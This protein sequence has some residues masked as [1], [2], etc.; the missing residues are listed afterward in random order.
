MHLFSSYRAAA[1]RAIRVLSLTVASLASLAAPTLAIPVLFDPDQVLDLGFETGANDPFAIHYLSSVGGALDAEFVPGPAL[2]PNQSVQDGFIL[3]DGT[4]NVS[5]SAAAGRARA[6]YQLRF[7]GR[8]LG[9]AG[10]RATDLRLMRFDGRANTWVRARRLIRDANARANARFLFGRRAR[11]ELGAFGVD[12]Q[13]SLVWGVTDVDGAYAIGA[14]RSLR[15][16]EPMSLW[17]L[18]A[19]LGGIAY[20]RR[21]RRVVDDAS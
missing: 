14:L 17:L 2:G 1:V 13:R 19:G 11:F 4:L 18:A 10:I 21:R 15:A 16:P 9:R 12:T 5:S 3:L 7:D 8:A 20:H 6:R